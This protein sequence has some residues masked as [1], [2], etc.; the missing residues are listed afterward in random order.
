MQKGVK[1]NNGTHMHGKD[2]QR[3]TRDGGQE[4]RGR[5]T[6]HA[7]LGMILDGIERGIL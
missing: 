3:R 7:D 4:A 6:Y 5:Q 1:T 2:K